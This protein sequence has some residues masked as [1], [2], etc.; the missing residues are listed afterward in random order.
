MRNHE[1]RRRREWK[2]N[3]TGVRERG[4]KFPGGPVKQRMNLFGMASR[5]LGRCGAGMGI[6]GGNRKGGAVGLLCGS[7]IW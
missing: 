2:A 5:G 4:E 1:R 3:R 6:I 7:V